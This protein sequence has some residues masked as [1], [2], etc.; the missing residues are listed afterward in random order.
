MIMIIIIITIN[1]CFYYY[2]YCYFSLLL[3]LLRVVNRQILSP[4]QNGLATH[5]ITMI[6]LLIMSIFSFTCRFIIRS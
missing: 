3:C 1:Y 6:S 4:P 2:H 5:L